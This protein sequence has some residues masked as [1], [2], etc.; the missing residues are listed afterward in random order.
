[1]A[2]G[3]NVNSLA[4]DDADDAP[5]LAPGVRQALANSLYMLLEELQIDIETFGDAPLTPSRLE[6]S[7]FLADLPK[8]TWRMDQAWREHLYEAGVSLCKRVE[9]G[10]PAD[11][12]CVA[13]EL[14]LYMAI[15]MTEAHISEGLYEPPDD[16]VSLFAVSSDD[17]DLSEF[18]DLIFQDLDFL[19]LYDEA[20]DGVERDSDKIK[21]LGL[22]NLDSE[23]W[24]TTFPNMTWVDEP[25]LDL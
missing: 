20:H 1:M 13:Q 23:S 5:G 19:M 2:P 25:D 24:F 6:E 4:E 14:W 8:I 22:A 21:A 11:P 7:L 12:T 17:C 10:G 9:S 16:A 3:F 18:T 15:Q